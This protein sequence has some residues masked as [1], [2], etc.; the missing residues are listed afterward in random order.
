[1]DFR[2]HI[3][4]FAKRFAE[5]EAALS[6]PKAF[7]NK[8]RAQDMAREYHSLKELIGHGQ[9]YLKVLA[10]LDENKALLKSEP[11]DSDMAVLA[12]EELRR[13]EQEERRLALELQRGILP[14]DP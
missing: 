14:P 13:L 7:E 2:P 1:M 10:D 6:D 11:S 3:D 12:Q 5:V 9:G 4:R 8:Q